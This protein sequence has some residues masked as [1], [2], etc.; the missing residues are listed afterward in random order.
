MRTK[1]LVLIAALAAP[2]SF[3]ALP[4]DQQNFKHAGS[5]GTGAGQGGKG[6]GQR[7]P[8]EAVRAAGQALID[9]GDPV[10]DKNARERFLARYKAAHSLD[11][12]DPAKVTLEI[13]EDKFPFAIPSR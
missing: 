12:A 3:A 11:K 2:L 5:G 9:S 4:K 13:G 1:L 7:G 8:G 6:Q 10:Y